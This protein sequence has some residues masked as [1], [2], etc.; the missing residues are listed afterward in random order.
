MGYLAILGRPGWPCVLAGI[1][2]FGN[3]EALAVMVFACRGVMVIC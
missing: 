1:D 3:I 2:G